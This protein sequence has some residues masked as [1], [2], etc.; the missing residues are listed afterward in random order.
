M[1]N[2]NVIIHALTV[3]DRCGKTVSESEIPVLTLSAGEPSFADVG[4]LLSVFHGMAKS[5]TI[6]AYCEDCAKTL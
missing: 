5:R 3:C 2:A 4:R 1:L 6:P